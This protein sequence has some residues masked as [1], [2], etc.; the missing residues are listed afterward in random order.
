MRDGKISYPG[1]PKVEEISFKTRDFIGLARLEKFHIE[2]MDLDPEHQGI[3]LRL[4]GVA[5]YVR[6]ASHDF[7]EDHRLTWWNALWRD[8][9][10]E[11]LFS[12][13]VAAFSAVL[14][15]Y[16]LYKEIKA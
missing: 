7:S 11:V 6:T 8:R 9:R 3:R 14:A 4:H 2:A 1:Y 15:G 13:T 16:R 12:I 10:L 5:G